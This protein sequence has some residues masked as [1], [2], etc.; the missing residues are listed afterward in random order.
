M[1][2]LITYDLVENRFQESKHTQVKNSMKAL[3]YLDYFTMSIDEKTV[4]HYLPNTCLWKRDTTPQQAK[5][6]LLNIARKHNA[7]IERLLA[8]EFTDTFAAIPG[9]R[10]AHE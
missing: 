10:Y 4:T 3:G 8:L 1:D 6:D 7:D 9:K 2:A 5:T